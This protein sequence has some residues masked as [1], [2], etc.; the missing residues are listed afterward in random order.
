MRRTIPVLG[1]V[2][3][4]AVLAGCGSSPQH[5]GGAAVPVGAVSPTSAAPASA[6]SAATPPSPSTSTAPTTVHTSGS[7]QTLVLGPNG[8]GDL[9]LGMSYASAMRTGLLTGNGSST[10]EGCN[11]DYTP[12]SAHG[13]DAPVFFDGKQGLVSF[14]AYPGLSTPEGVKIGSTLEKLLK[15]YPDWRGGEENTN[16]GR[17]WAKV[18]GRS[19]AVY[20]ISVGQEKVIHMNLQLRTQ[21][22]YE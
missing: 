21:N 10:P 17:G 15:A 3:T 22:C 12:K 2:L 16:D 19:D 4:L 13:A 11:T 1:A 6:A 18:P 5:V 7:F 9:K 8:L 20:N 14:T